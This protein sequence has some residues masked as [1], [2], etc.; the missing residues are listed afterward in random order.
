L[1]FSL[2]LLLLLPLARFCSCAKRFGG[3]VGML[4]C[5]MQENTTTTLEGLRSTS[6]TDGSLHH[7][8]M[9]VLFTTLYL[10]LSQKCCFEVFSEND[11]VIVLACSR[12][13]GIFVLITTTV[14]ASLPAQVEH[15]I[16]SA[17]RC[18]LW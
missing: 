1:P 2:L 6:S 11:R 14:L 7:F 9:C 3:A 15:L 4:E 10:S 12:A 5:W 17:V 8:D 18:P 13:D 16:I